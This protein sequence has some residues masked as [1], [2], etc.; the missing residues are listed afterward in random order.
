MISVSSMGPCRQVSDFTFVEETEADLINSE[1]CSER[2]VKE[3][4]SNIRLNPSKENKRVLEVDT[5]KMMM[6]GGRVYMKGDGMVDPKII[7]KP[8]THGL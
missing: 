5:M 2:S 8:R 3:I 6:N 1:W 4:E 7:V